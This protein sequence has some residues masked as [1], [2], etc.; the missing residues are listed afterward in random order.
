M[1][2]GNPAAA[3]EVVLERLREAGAA[4]L[5]KGKLLAR[6]GSR[7]E[8][9][10]KD[11]LA[12]GRVANLGSRARPRFVLFEHFR[13]LER[14]LEHIERQALSPKAGGEGTVA[15][16]TQKQLARGLTGEPKKKIPEAFAR[17][18]AERALLRF[19]RG[20]NLYLAHR[21]QLH[22]LLAREGRQGIPRA[23]EP[24]PPVAVEREVVL[25][26]YRRLKEKSGFSHVEI[27]ALAR[28]AGCPL[29][30]LKAFILAESRAG[31]AVLGLGDWSLSTEETRAGAVE[32]LGRPHLLVSFE[33]G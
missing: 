32:L 30:S 1:A 2:S 18:F 21:D 8:G 22:R 23:A 10:L 26:A 13:P 9:A 25:S 19:R 33:T 12:A 7:G 3:G 20:R 4:G 11:L 16:F 29:A 27:A 24:S 14:A 17:L 31:R 5:P 28:E 6:L 15:L